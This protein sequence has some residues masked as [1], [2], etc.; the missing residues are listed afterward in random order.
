MTDS[1]KLGELGESKAISEFI[2]DG[3]DVFTQFS[4]K[5]PFDLVI[6]RDGI[7]QRVEVK[8]TKTRT[9]YDTGWR[10]Q[11]RKIRSNLSETKIHKFDKNQ[12]DLLAV[13][14]APLDRVVILNSNEI[15]VSSAL[16]IL[17]EHLGE[18]AE[19][20]LLQRS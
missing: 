12:S 19:S 7:L 9:P 11:L 10:I 18:V 17:D 20:G 16:T 14:I 3:F 13:Y 15:T 2:R 1:T 4:G 6:C 8:T 5:A